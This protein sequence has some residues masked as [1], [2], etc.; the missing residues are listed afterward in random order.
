M[1]EPDDGTG[2]VVTTGAISAI[3]AGISSWLTT[4][5]KYRSQ[6]RSTRRSVEERLDDIEKWQASANERLK[7]IEENI[8]MVRRFI[9][10][11]GP[12]SVP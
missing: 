10:R 4:M 7:N 9:M 5:L 2:L 11:E 6:I 8:S 12:P 1:M 3:I